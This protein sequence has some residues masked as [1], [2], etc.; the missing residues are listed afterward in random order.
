MGWM[1]AGGGR[2]GGVLALSVDGEA[3]GEAEAAQGSLLGGLRGL[4][5]RRSRESKRRA[6]SSCRPRKFRRLRQ[7]EDCCTMHHRCGAKAGK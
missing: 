3:R 1:C 7:G 5:R 6:R 2:A 4:R